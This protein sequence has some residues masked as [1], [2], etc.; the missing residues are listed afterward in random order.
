MVVEDIRAGNERFLDVR[1][2]IALPSGGTISGFQEFGQSVY[3]L[4]RP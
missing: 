2:P 4:S 3:V 1:E